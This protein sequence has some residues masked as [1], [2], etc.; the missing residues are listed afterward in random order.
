MHEKQAAFHQEMVD[1]VKSKEAT[2]IFEN[3]IRKLDFKAFTKEGIIQNYS[4]DYSTIEHNPMG[5]INVTLYINHD[6]GLYIF[7]TLDKDNGKLTDNGGGN[8]TKLEKLLENE[9]GK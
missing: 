6:K 7:F 4:V 9:H 1:I 8:S 5:G 2:N 3:G